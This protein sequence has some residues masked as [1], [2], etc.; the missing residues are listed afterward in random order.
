ML[1]EHIYTLL[2]T[3]S[4]K[5][6]ELSVYIRYLNRCNR[7]NKTKSPEQLGVLE[8]HH[9]LPKAKDMFPDYQDRV[10]YPWNSVKLTAVQH[11]MAHWLL[12]RSYGYGSQS[13]AFH[14]MT[15]KNGVRIKSLS[16]IKKLKEDESRRVRE[17]TER[18]EFGAQREDVKARIRDT[19]QRKKQEDPT[20]GKMSPEALEKRKE[21]GRKEAEA[22]LCIFQQPEFKEKHCTA[23]GDRMRAMYEAGYRYEKTQRTQSKETTGSKI[24]KSTVTQNNTQDYAGW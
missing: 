14:F 18:G 20:Y 1:S 7:I 16:V 13:L 11:V 6:K 17:L 23:N 2:K 19:V 9:I 12:W 8:D 24:G 22:G 21:A 15:N 10:I 4:N 5:E 3:K